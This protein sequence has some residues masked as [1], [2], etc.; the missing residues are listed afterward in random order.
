MNLDIAEVAKATPRL[1]AVGGANLDILARASTHLATAD[2]TPG[3]VA[4][5]PGGVA[6]N[7]AENLARL[8]QNV[9]LISAVGGD[10]FGQS[11]LRKTKASG[12]DVAGVHVVPGHIT[13][14]YIS[15]H[16][17]DGDLA[18]AINDMRVL[19]QLTPGLLRDHSGALMRANGL[20]LDC[21]LASDSLAWLLDAA[22]QA[23]VFIDAVSAPKCTRLRPFLGSIHTLKL[24]RLEAEVLT[25]R[26]VVE[27]EDALAATTHLQA[28]GVK[29][30]VI[31]LSSKGVCWRDENG[32]F[33]HLS[34]RWVG[35]DELV[36]TNGAGD[37]LMS[38]LI[39][40]WG[41]GMA[42]DQAVDFAAACA[43]LTLLSPWANTPELSVK[44]VAQRLKLGRIASPAMG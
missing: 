27:P 3:E 24:N 21:N 37:A 19:D 22:P 2:S 14:T 13:A 18:A 34:P 29:R 5:S 17:A 15:L 43:E 23:T 7:I 16:G 11:V 44:A 9:A 41:Q 32:V 33:G 6:R 25:G 40:G 8:G 38:G 30:V 1:V 39:Y 10:D 20:L 12:V 35:P 26:R 36:N 28:A 42:L 31:G 4:F